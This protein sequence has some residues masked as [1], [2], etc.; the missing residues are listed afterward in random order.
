MDQRTYLALIAP[1]GLNQREAEILVRRE[2]RDRGE[3][4]WPTMEI[5]VFPGG[6][7]CLLI[8]RRCVRQRIYI[9]AA[10]LRV[11]IDHCE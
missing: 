4:P 3:D 5:E 7:A 8:A 11:V 2:L 9:S 6:E 10:A 1:P